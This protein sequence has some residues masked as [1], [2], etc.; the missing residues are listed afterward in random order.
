MESSKK[1]TPTWSYFKALAPFFLPPVIAAL[2]VHLGW[3]QSWWLCPA[4]WVFYSGLR[5][6]RFRSSSRLETLSSF[7]LLLTSAIALSSIFHIQV[8]PIV[9]LGI[10]LVLIWASTKSMPLKV[11]VFPLILIVGVY[12]L[13]LTPMND[14][15]ISASVMS[16]LGALC[17]YLL[18]S[19]K[20]KLPKALV[21]GT[22][23]VL[24]IGLMGF[25]IPVTE[26]AS[27]TALA[28]AVICFFT[29]IALCR[30]LPKPST[31]P[32]TSENP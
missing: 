3:K 12:L 23:Y 6:A 9:L 19:G 16:C 21:I 14:N 27:R 10:S 17:T 2:A 8:N 20:A 31:P 28:Y 7:A 11:W 24:C 29:Y 5:L 13:K 1:P 32:S 26:L 15:Q 30:S 4:I 25:F 22:L 18:V